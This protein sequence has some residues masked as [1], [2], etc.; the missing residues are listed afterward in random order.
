MSRITRIAAELYRNAYRSGT[1]RTADLGRGARL[2]ARVERD[3]QMT[4]TIARKTAR[5]GASELETFRNHCMVPP[6][7]IRWPAQDQAQITRDGATWWVVVYR[8]IA[9]PPDEEGTML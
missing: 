3:G 5:I 7:A 8:W 1:D 6:E 2:A 4:L 9:P